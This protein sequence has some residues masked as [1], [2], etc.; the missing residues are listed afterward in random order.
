M[1]NRFLCKNLI[2]PHQMKRP[3]YQSRLFLLTAI[4]LLTSFTF[5]GSGCRL[6]KR[7][8]QSQAEK[9]QE[10]ASK[11]AN[12]EYEKALKQHYKHQNKDTKKMMKRTKKQAA[13]YNKPKKRKGL[14]KPKCN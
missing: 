6:L 1:I 10:E 11:A 9:K 13:T 14:F 2:V 4:L 7:D 3:V 12:A 5:L 8:K